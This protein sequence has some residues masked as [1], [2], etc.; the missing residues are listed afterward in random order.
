MNNFEE[1]LKQA[2]GD[3]DLAA[4]DIPRIELYMDQVLTL[5]DEGLAGNK[6]R[7]EDKLLTKTMINNYSKEHIIL[8][9]KGKKY[10]RE[11]LM[12]LLC[13]LNLKQ[14][15][16]LGD[17]KALVAAE[18]G[19]ISFEQAYQASLESKTRLK[20]R[21]ETAL[22]EEL[23]DTDFADREKLLSAV[24]AISAAANELRRVCEGIVDEMAQ[25]T[26]A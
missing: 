1:I 9:V 5:F 23:G 25:N 17:I 19:K 3:V 20:A 26:T 24:L 11:Q 7:P 18:S 14:A 12:Q 4:G 21:V 6:R 15:L 8:P 10:S 16:S 13:I 2:F 22:R